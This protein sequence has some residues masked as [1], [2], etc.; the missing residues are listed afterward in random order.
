MKKKK[1]KK[2]VEDAVKIL[3]KKL[4]RRKALSTGAKVGAAA[5]GGIVVGFLGGWFAKPSAPAATIT[6]TLVSTATKTVTAPGTTVTVTKTQVS[7]APTTVTTTAIVRKPTITDQW[8]HGP[9]DSINWDKPLPWTK[10]LTKVEVGTI[11]DNWIKRFPFLEKYRP[12]KTAAIGGYV[13]PEG[14][15]EAVKGVDKLRFLNYGG[16]PHDPATAMGLAAFEDLTG[17]RIEY[18]E[19]EELTL[20]TKTVSIMTAKSDAID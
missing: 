13:L 11:P 19:M 14:W 20:W 18:E 1:P 6:S 5:V 10:R 8:G 16:M 12:D 4:N 3:D 2:D 9:W 7:T 17:I 15:K